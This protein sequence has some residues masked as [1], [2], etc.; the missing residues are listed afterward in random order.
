MC[1]LRMARARIQKK[2]HCLF[3]A[4]G[5]RLG[6]GGLVALGPQFRVRSLLQQQALCTGFGN[7]PDDHP[8]HVRRAEMI[9]RVGFE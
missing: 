4:R 8:L 3:V 2:F 1:A 5:G 7:V 9:V 6:E